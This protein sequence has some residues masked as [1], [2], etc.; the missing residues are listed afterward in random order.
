M[1][2]C[3]TARSVPNPF[4]MTAYIFRAERGMSGEWR[5]G[6]IILI[7]GGGGGVKEEDLPLA[8]ARSTYIVCEESWVRGFS[9]V[10]ALRRQISVIAKQKINGGVCG[11]LLVVA[12]A[13]AER[14]GDIASWVP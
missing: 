13:E 7:G 14:Q 6:S 11:I 8:Y 5:R 12:L 9:I 3:F 1:L 2:V 10:H 4:G